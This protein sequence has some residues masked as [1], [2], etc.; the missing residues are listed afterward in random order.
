[1]ERTNQTLESYL[2]V[3]CSHQQDNWVD[4]LPLAEFAFNN[5]INTLMNTTPFFAN[6]GFHPSFDVS[7]TTDTNNLAAQELSIHLQH[8]HEELRAELA[9]SNEQMAIYYDHKWSPPPEYSPGDFVLLLH[10][11]IKTT[12]PS[13]KLDYCYLGPFEILERHG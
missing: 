11:N 1:M 2:W 5:C 12:R 10:R 9:H 8:I 6:M 4:Y 7:I 3:F 13:N